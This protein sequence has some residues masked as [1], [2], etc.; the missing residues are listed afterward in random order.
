MPVGRVRN[1]HYRKDPGPSDEVQE[2]IQAD[3]AHYVNLQGDPTGSRA[4]LISGRCGRASV[5]SDLALAARPHGTPKASRP[6]SRARLPSPASQAP[7]TTPAEPPKRARL[8]PAGPDPYGPSGLSAGTRSLIDR[9]IG[10]DKVKGQDDPGP[11]GERYCILATD[12]SSPQR[13]AT[14]RQVVT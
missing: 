8:R 4:I 13:R 7:P 11:S 1:E 14:V 6:P 3:N 9:P 10:I 12:F 2:S 5:S